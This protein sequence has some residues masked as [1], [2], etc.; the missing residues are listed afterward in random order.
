VAQVLA[1]RFSDLA[2]PP[3]GDI[4]YATTNRQAALKSITARADSVIVVGERFSSNAA[5][6]LELAQSAGCAGA[7]LV[8]EAAAIDWRLVPS[9]GTIGITAAASTP[10]QAVTDIL[11]ALAGRYALHVETVE[12][13]SETTEFRPVAIT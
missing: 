1:D 2:V 13:P 11:E 12:G 9:G 6:L 4:C 3:S 5:R 10:D 8:A 7:Q